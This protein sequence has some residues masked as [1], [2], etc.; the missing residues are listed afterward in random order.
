MVTTSNSSKILLKARFH[1][2]QQKWL[3]YSHGLV[4][5]TW[6]DLL[7]PQVKSIEVIPKP[8]HKRTGRKL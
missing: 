5:F 2:I 6:E 3:F 4:G 7:L 8:K 1:K